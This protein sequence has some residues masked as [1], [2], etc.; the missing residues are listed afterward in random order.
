VLG[1]KAVLDRLRSVMDVV[2]REMVKFGAV[3]AVAFVVDVGV[4]NLL[5]TGVLPGSDGPLAHKP[6]TAKTISV[7]LA[8]LT[9]WVGNR[10]WT[11]RHRRR[12]SAGRELVL[13]AVMNAGGLLISLAILAFS[14]Y[15]LGFTS[16]LA[17]NLA[18]NVIGVGVATLFRFWAYRTL[19]FTELRD[20]PA[21]PAEVPD[22]VPPIPLSAQRLQP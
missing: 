5:R 19:V 13:F 8:T 3:G 6:L 4:F 2:Y 12:A 10:Y 16:A 11:F 14:H 15:A 17:D 22:A 1:V 20:A 9:A 18:G 7:I 21:S